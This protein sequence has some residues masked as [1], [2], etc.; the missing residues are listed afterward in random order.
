ME[1]YGKKTNS[2]EEPAKRQQR[3]EEKVKTKRTKGENKKNQSKPR[4]TGCKDQENQT[5]SGRRPLRI[6]RG[7][8]T[9]RNERELVISVLHWA[10]PI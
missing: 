2:S 6:P 3:N 10:N 9:S 4:I 1:N 7:R 5:L 8:N